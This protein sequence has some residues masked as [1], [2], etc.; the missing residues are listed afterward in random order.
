MRVGLRGRPA[1]MAINMAAR[2][3]E[4][5]AGTEAAYSEEVLCSNWTPAPQLAFVPGV[6]EASAAHP[7]ADPEPADIEGLLGRIYAWQQA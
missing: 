6:A 5:E 4:I 3:T 1:R 2:K 7:A